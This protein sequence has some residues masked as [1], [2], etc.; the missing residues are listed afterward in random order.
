MR[1]I[2]APTSYFYQSDNSVFKLVL[3]KIRP[4]GIIWVWTPILHLETLDC[5]FNEINNLIIVFILMNL[6][7]LCKIDLSSL[8]SHH[9]TQ[10]KC[11]AW[12]DKYV[13]ISDYF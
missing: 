6:L 9:R 12:F 8:P 5:K 11:T 13:L 7:G 4:I 1:I 2:V 3:V 10:L